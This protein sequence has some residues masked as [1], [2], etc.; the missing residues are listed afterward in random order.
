M[1]VDLLRNDISRI[2]KVN[3][4]KTSKYFPEIIE[5]KNVYHTYCDIFGELKE[6]ISLYK[7]IKAMFPGGSISGCPKIK[8]CQTIE[9]LENRDRGIYTG[10]FGYINFNKKM[11][12]NIL[13]R[14][15]LLKNS[16]VKFSVGGGITLL[17][18][19]KDE[20][21]ETIHKADNIWKSLNL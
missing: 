11:V 5:L 12:F 14:T 21:E 2:C 9:S 19:P 8:A 15:V 16:I 7:I 18:N 3:S 6:D 4:V 10:T 1:I 17:S 13:I 20:F